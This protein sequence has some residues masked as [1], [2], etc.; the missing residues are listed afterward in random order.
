MSDGDS[1]T[2]PQ[3]KARVHEILIYFQNTTDP[4]LLSPSIDF[5]LSTLL[6]RLSV[7]CHPLQRNCLVSS[8]SLYLIVYMTSS[9]GCLHGHLKVYF[10]LLLIW[11]FLQPQ[12]SPLLPF[13]AGSR[14]QPTQPSMD[15]VP[16]GGTMGVT[17][18]GIQLG[19]HRLQRDPGSHLMPILPTSPPRSY[20]SLEVV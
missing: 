18:I 1:W 14:T 16:A 13:S 2:L 20:H 4:D 9:L 11:A 12:P 10:Q 3:R 8:R 19:Y 6:S 7:S 17:T 15:R 5:R